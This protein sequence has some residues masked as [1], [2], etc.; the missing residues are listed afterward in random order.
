VIEYDGTGGNQAPAIPSDPF[1]KNKLIF[2]DTSKGQK[3]QNFPTLPTSEAIERMLV[4][5]QREESMGG[6]SPLSYGQIDQQMPASGTIALLKSSMERVYPIKTAIQR[7]YCWGAQEAV[8]QY[9]TGKFG[10]VKFTVTEKG[11]RRMRVELTRKEID[12]TAKFECSLAMESVQ[13]DLEMTAILSEL[14]KNGIIDM[15]TARELCPLIDDPDE[16]QMRLDREEAFNNPGIKLRKMAAALIDEGDEEGAKYFLDQLNAPPQ[17]TQ[18]SAGSGAPTS[19][20]PR[21]M[22]PGARIGL[23]MN[24]PAKQ[25]MIN[26]R[27]AGGR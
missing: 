1:V 14:H 15:Q 13:A 23:A 7:M 17:E 25:A 18:Q 10:K 21:P 22:P 3:L 27:M 2:L 20:M 4:G 12:D 16:V 11:N 9:K 19:G 24:A 6:M 5:V 8:S 26:S